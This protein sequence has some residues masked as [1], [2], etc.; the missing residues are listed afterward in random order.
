MIRYHY[1]D[2]VYVLSDGASFSIHFEGPGSFEHPN[3]TTVEIS[4][5]K[6]IRECFD[7]LDDRRKHRRWP[8]Q[9]HGS[10]DRSFGEEIHCVINWSE[11]V[12]LHEE[13]G[14]VEHA[15]YWRAAIRSALAR[16]SALVVDT[17][18]L[19]PEPGAASA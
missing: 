6:T 4:C 9:F 17:R 16:A 5:A 2:K 7:D 14:E 10:T 11:F 15:N 1:D 13:H 19:Q 12:R 8:F 3:L 18:I